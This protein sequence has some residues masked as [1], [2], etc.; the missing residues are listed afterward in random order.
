MLKHNQAA[1]GDPQPCR[2][3]SDGGARHRLGCNVRAA[4]YVQR[5]VVAK[6][7]LLGEKGFN[8]GGRGGEGWGGKI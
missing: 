5:A 2:C 7:S 8:A 6:S 3:G 4:G 1:A